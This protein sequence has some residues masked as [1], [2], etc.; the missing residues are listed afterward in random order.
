MRSP[1]VR[2][3]KRAT[4][5]ELGSAAEAIAADFLR[6]RGLVVL[7]RNYRCRL[8]EIDLVARDSDTLV[9]VEVRLRTSAAFGGAAA[10]I[11]GAK[12]ARMTRAA[13]HYLATLGRE[14]SCRF[15]ALLLDALDPARVEWLRDIEM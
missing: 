8:G 9:F 4:R 14:P 7:T 5:A 6:S 13:R 2:S 12:R 3:N 11:G 15:D 10:S 1:L